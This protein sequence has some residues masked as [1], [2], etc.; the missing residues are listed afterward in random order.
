MILVELSIRMTN[1]NN[2]VTKFF[3]CSAIVILVAQ[4]ALAFGQFLSAIAPANA[5]STDLAG[6]TALPF[7][8][9]GGYFL[10]NQ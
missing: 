4:T 1:L 5:S 7:M 6:P 8:I 10:N 9:F 3:I 2:D